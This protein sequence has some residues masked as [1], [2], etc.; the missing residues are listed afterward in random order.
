MAQ[1]LAISAAAQPTLA[2]AADP[3]K[4][5]QP[6]VISCLAA[7]N[8]DH[9]ACAVAKRQLAEAGVNAPAM[10]SHAQEMLKP[11]EQLWLA[12]RLKALWKSTTPSGSLT[13]MDWLRETGRLLKHLP[14][15]I[16]AYAIDQ[17]IASSEKG[18]TP[19]AGAILHHAKP[20]LDERRRVATR[21]R[22]VVDGMP[23]RRD[24][25]YVPPEE[26]CTPEQAREILEK[27]GM[28]SAFRT[29]KKP[30]KRELREPTKE[31]LDELAREMRG[32]P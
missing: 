1:E 18:F 13:A 26:R 23:Y 29:D 10:L 14:L 32:Q 8:W 12:D 2:L 20:L 11:V 25:D 3:T 21:L 5:M 27:F 28:S 9:G 16:V 19:N 30:S 17:A 4:W 7:S 6:T 24:P 31:E 15:D 22:F